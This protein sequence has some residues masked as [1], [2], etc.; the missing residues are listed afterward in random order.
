MFHAFGAV[1]ERA[2]VR[3]LYREKGRTKCS[4]DLVPSGLF[5][6]NNLE[7]NDGRVL[8]RNASRITM[9]CWTTKSGIFK[10][11]YLTKS[12]LEG[13]RKGLWS[14]ILTAL[15]CNTIIL[16]SFERYALPQTAAQ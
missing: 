15:F 14:I 7:I 1:K 13:K 12:S 3:K 6:S 8:F 11:L 4:D 5:M 9:F 10:M 16:Y 2:K